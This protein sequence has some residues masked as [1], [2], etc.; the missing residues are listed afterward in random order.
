MTEGR[1]C[2]VLVVE[3]DLVLAGEARF[4]GLALVGG[5]LVVE[6]SAMFEGMARV[7]G[8]TRLSDAGVFSGSRC[9]VLR[10]LNGIPS[11]HAPFL[12]DNTYINGF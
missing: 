4:Q 8:G 7:G 5:D 6:E 2:G 10:A 3:G 12:V 11:L 9:P 1:A